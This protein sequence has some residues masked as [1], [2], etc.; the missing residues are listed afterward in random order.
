MLMTGRKNS[1]VA[2]VW[3][4]NYGL[5]VTEGG[6]GIGCDEI[7]CVGTLP[8]GARVATISEIA[9]FF[10]DCDSVDLVIAR[11]TAPDYCRERTQVIDAKD[12]DRG[13][14]TAAYLDPT[15]QSFVLVPSIADPDRPW[16]IAR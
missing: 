13:G 1:F 5:S 9:G 15:T 6:A 14:T 10:E 12:L 3:A 16:R 7:G 8:G 4:D 11:R 2:D